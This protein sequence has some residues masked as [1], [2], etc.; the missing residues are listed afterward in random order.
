MEAQT[1]LEKAQKEIRRL[2]A[3]N[4]MF[5]ENEKIYRDAYRRLVEW[6]VKGIKQNETKQIK[7]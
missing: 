2:R 1:E 7:D 6:W 4:T 5:R 3:I